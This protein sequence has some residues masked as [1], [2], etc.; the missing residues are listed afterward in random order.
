[1]HSYRYKIFS[2]EDIEEEVVENEIKGK[3]LLFKIVG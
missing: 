1:M 2:L 3:N